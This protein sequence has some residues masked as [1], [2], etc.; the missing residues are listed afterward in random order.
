M[1][2]AAAG[3]AG[4]IAL[5]YWAVRQGHLQPFGFW[6]RWV[7]SWSDPLLRPI[8]RILVR[9]GRNPQDAP[10]W[11]LGGAVLGGILLVALSRWLT[12]LIETLFALR[13]AGVRGYLRFGLNALFSFL[14][15]ALIV[16]VISS[17]FGAGRFS[18]LVRWTWLMTDWLVE[19]IRRRM[20]P[21][22]MLDLSP[23]VAYLALLVAQALVAALLR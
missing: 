22:G 16:R 13:H 9:R 15:L 19:P 2:L 3:T 7:R 11:L 12:G 5:T 14:M 18:R 4:L 23:L 10:L 6:P 17:W 1:A 20:P 8:E 21:F